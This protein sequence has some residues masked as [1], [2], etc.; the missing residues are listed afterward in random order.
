[1]CTST[2]LVVSRETSGTCLPSSLPPPPASRCCLAL[3][4]APITMH[5][6]PAARNLRPALLALPTATQC[7]SRAAAT[8]KGR[9][10]PALH[11][12]SH[13][14]IRA[15][16]AAEEPPSRAARVGVAF[17]APPFRALVGGAPPPLTSEALGE[18]CKLWRQL[19]CASCWLRA[20][21]SPSRT[22]WRAEHST[23]VL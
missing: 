21:C 8:Y 15:T 11:F 22:R 6:I 5:T 19:R 3:R 13:R 2:G 12:A 4:D 10:A 14:D 23:A 20:C 17:P 1:M 9:P 7:L 18:G 16:R